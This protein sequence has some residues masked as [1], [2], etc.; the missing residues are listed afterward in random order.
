M[1]VFLVYC[2]F[3]ISNHFT[4]EIGIFP[5]M[6]IAATTLFFDPGWPRRLLLGDQ[7]EARRL[8]Q[9]AEIYPYRWAGAMMVFLIFWSTSQTL[10]PLRHFTYPGDVAWTYGGHRFAWRMKLVDRWT[11]RMRAA[12]YIP[13]RHEVLVPELRGLLTYRQHRKAATRPRM[14]RQIAAQLAEKVRRKY[15]VEDVRV[16]LYMPVGYN[17]REATPLI[18]PTVDMASAKDDATPPSW[19]IK[20]NDKPLRRREEFLSHYDFPSIGEMVKLMGLPPKKDCKRKNSLWWRCSTEAPTE[21]QQEPA[22]REEEPV[23]SLNEPDEDSNS[24]DS[25]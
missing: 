15:G 6:T 2:A 1:A 8:V 3:H 10:I 25:L 17:N 12:I 16:Q 5:W 22:V 18:D 23:I 20:D 4:F 14:A 9:G 11:P 7:T 24:D 19:I 13:D 21:P